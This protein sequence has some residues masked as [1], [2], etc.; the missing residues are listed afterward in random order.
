MTDISVGDAVY[1]ANVGGGDTSCVANGYA[2]GGAGTSATYAISGTVTTGLTVVYQ[3]AAQPSSTAANCLINNAAGFPKYITFQN[4][5]VLS[6]NVFALQADNGWQFSI[7]NQFFNNVFADNDA[8]VN[9]DINCTAAASEGSSSFGCWDGNTLGFYQNVLTSRNP[10]NWSVVNC[11]GGSCVN[12]FPTSVNCA[13]SS[14]DPTCL[15]YSGFAG[16]TPLVTYPSGAC[17]YDGSNSS[18]CPLMALPWANNFTYTDVSYMGSSS[19]PNQGVNT[20]QLN[21]AMTQTK[22]V[23]PAGANC[24]THGPY[25]D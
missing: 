22:Y 20:T 16:S 6:P 3:V 25:P 12:S 1:A 19:Y 4:N 17:V 15:G 5:T 7:D 21:T 24:G 23:C 8:G 2:V 14:A 18:N 9:S 10:A 13:G 11:P